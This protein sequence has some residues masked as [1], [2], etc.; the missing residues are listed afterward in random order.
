MTTWVLALCV[1]VYVVTPATPGG[2]GPPRARARIANKSGE[3]TREQLLRGNDVLA[4][5]HI[6][7]GQAVWVTQTASRVAS[8]G[9]EYVPGE[10]EDETILDVLGELESLGFTGQFKPCE[11]GQV[12]CLTCHRLSPADDTVFRQLRRLEGAEPVAS[13]AGLRPAGRNGVNY[14]IGEIRF[15]EKPVSPGHRSGSACCTIVT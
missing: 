12:E 11:G 10:G 13:Y 5:I 2:G 6:V 1:R 4:A 15:R 9:M 8:I 14:L 7:P 3:V